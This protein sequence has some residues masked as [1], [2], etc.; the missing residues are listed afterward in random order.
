MRRLVGMSTGAIGAFAA[1]TL[2][3]TNETVAGAVHGH[4]VP[5]R[6]KIPQRKDAVRELSSRRQFDVLVIGGGATGTGCALDATTR[7]LSTAL[8]EKEDFAAGTSSRSTKLVHGGVRYLEKAFKNLDYGQLKLVFEALHER[9]TILDIAPHLARSLPIMTPC[10]AW[11]EVPYYWMGM[12]LYDLIAGTRALSWSHFVPSG[13]AKSAFP[14]LNEKR[15]GSKDGKTLKGTVSCG[16][17]HAQIMYS[18]F[19]N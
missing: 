16:V 17:Q 12:K 1:Y 7:G 8:V 5:D 13:R 15:G 11:W 10:Y 18:S 14:T 4:V 19:C 9:R 3:H 2:Y 6:R